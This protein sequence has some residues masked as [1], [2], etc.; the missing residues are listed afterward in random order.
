MVVRLMAVC[1]VPTPSVP[2][3]SPL[4]RPGGV[5]SAGTATE[6]LMV[7]SLVLGLAAMSWQ[8]TKCCN[9]HRW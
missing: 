1:V 3:G 6:K 7:K 8:R 4:D 5:V 2:V 9:C